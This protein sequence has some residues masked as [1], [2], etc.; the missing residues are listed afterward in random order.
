MPLEAYIKYSGYP[1]TK[2]Q[3]EPIQ[4]PK[5]VEEFIQRDVPFFTT[6]PTEQKKKTVFSEIE[7]D[8]LEGLY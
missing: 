6:A 5:M 2:I 4:T 7:N 1:L 8:E 3:F